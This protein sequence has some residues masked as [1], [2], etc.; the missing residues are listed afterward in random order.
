MKTALAQHQKTKARKRT[1]RAKARKRGP[2]GPSRL[3]T[4]AIGVHDRRTGGSEHLEIR[5][6]RPTS[7]PRSNS[8]RFQVGKQMREPRA[9]SAGFKGGRFRIVNP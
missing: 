3:R 1:Q 9:V 6:K 5:S 2:R 4:D 7:G 8:H